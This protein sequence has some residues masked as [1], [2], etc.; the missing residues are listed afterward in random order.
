MTG[1][2]TLLDPY[3]IY[4]VNDLQAIRND[5]TA[6]Y[7]LANDIDAS[8]TLLWNGGL[9]FGPIGSYQFGHPELRFS[10]CFDG[11]GHIISNLFINRPLEDEVGLFGV[12]ALNN[13][14][15]WIRNVG[16]VDC[17]ITGDVGVGCLVGFHE[18]NAQTISECYATGTIVSPMM[19]G[20]LLGYNGLT[21]E[22]CH[23]AVTITAISLVHPT[24][25]TEEIGGL[26]GTN[27]G[28]VGRCY[29]VGNITGIGVG[30]G[31]ISEFGGLIGYHNNGRLFQCYATGNISI[32]GSGFISE[33]G[34]L[35]GLDTGTL[36]TTECFATG[37]ITIVAVGEVWGVGGF[38]GYKDIPAFADCYARGN[39]SITTSGIWDGDIGG[40]VGYVR[41]GLEILR[42]YSTGS[43]TIV[44]ASFNNVGG[45]CGNNQGT[46]TNCF[47]DT[48]TSG[49]PTSDGGTGKT[50]AQ[51]K[52]YKTF[53]G[54]GFGTIWGITN[55]CNDGYPYLLDVT[56]SCKWAPYR[57]NILIDQLIY[58]HAE[59]M[60]R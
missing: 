43:I 11:K 26:I 50:T 20:G 5:L 39:I 19:V 32:T 15:G 13:P 48:Q 51:M 59:R 18:W 57:G 30:S 42:S 8:G 17:D 34:G 6:Y 3:I 56:A 46:I 29:A 9:G 55:A 40:M 53:T 2:G 16:M 12:T 25:G 52:K 60:V 33:V 24:W 23:A 4:D 10:G 35:T 37:H 54:W 7:E 27:D 21:V 45:F 1:S 49:Q 36:P 22:D 38:T 14:G 28:D 58:Q 44:G 47:W 31:N 41:S